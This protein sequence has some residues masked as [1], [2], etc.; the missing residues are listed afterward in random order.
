MSYFG[1]STMGRGRSAHFGPDPSSKL[2][3]CGFVELRP[4]AA[5]WPETIR[6]PWVSKATQIV[7]EQPENAVAFVSLSAL[8]LPHS[9]RTSIWSDGS[10]SVWGSSRLAPRYLPQQVPLSPVP[11]PPLAWTS[12]PGQALSPEWSDARNTRGRER[13]IA[14]Q[15]PPRRCSSAFQPWRTPRPP[16][17]LAAVAAI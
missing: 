7:S 3:R 11:R 15:S 17:R 13:M 6:P 4:G 2:R 10:A 8:R 12:D 14:S 1:T 9:D 5:I 16:Q